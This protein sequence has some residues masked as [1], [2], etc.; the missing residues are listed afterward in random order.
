MARSTAVDRATNGPWY[1]NTDVEPLVE[2]GTLAEEETLADGGSSTHLIDTPSVVTAAAVP[3]EPTYC[4]CKEVTIGFIFNLIS[5]SNC[6]LQYPPPNSGHPRFPIRPHVKLWPRQ[7]VKKNRRHMK[8]N[9]EIL[10]A[11]WDLW[12]FFQKDS[13]KGFGVPDR[14][15]FDGTPVFARKRPCKGGSILKSFSLLILGG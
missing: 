9:P 8:K 4:F 3:A 5:I 12:Y 1:G 11:I 7:S 6:N 2:E 14:I 10:D 15:T 13:S